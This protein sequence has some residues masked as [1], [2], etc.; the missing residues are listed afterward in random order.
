MPLPGPSSARSAASQ[1]RQLSHQRTNRSARWHGNPTTRPLTDAERA[2]QEVRVRGP[3]RLLALLL[4]L[5]LLTYLYA[6]QWVIG[7]LLATPPPLHG[8]VLRALLVI[9]RAYPWLQL[10]ALLILTAL[11]LH[12]CIAAC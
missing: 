7:K 1:A 8:W 4:S 3:Q 2:V 12:L 5:T 11:L 6:P 10:T 9:V